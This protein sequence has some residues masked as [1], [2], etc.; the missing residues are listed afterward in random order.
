MKTRKILTAI[1]LVALACVLAC[2][3]LVQANT[4]REIAQQA[5]PSVVI[6]VLEDT[7]GQPISLGSGF[8][9]AK[10]VIATNLHVIEGAATGYAKIVGTKTKYKVAGIVASDGIRDL[11]LLAIQ[12]SKAPPLPLERSWQPAVGDEVYAIGNPLGL[13]GTFSQ[14]IIS[15]VRRVGSDS[16]LQI[17]APISPG[18]S[19]GPVLDSQGKVIGVAV[20]TFKA[21]QGLNFAIPVSYLAPLLSDMKPATPLSTRVPVKADKSI[22]DDLGGWSSKSVF[23]TQLTWQYSTATGYYSFSLRNVLREPVKEVYCLVIFSDREGNPLDVDIVHYAG[24]IPGGLAKRVAS[25]V[26]ESVQKMTTE[27]EFRVLDFQIAE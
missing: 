14:G 20:A 9:V 15:G 1:G 25:Q 5:F 2:P 23:G 12:D 24:V 3:S 8:F 11:A 16:I 13:E 17:T 27:I 7:N 4:A 22:L 21:G 18:S 6:L 26:H 10:G 19:G